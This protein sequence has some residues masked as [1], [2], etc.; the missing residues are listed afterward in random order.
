MTRRRPDMKPLR[1][2]AIWISVGIFGI[3]AVH[4]APCPTPDGCD[5][6]LLERRSLDALR[7][8]GA[9]PGIDGRPGAPAGPPGG[10]AGRRSEPVGSQAPVATGFIQSKPNPGAAAALRSEARVLV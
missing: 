2:I 1:L 6:A 3:S 10:A 4:A 9:P 8:S 7:L 5:P